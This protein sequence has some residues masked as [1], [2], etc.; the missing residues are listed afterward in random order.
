[1][2]LMLPWVITDILLTP[3]VQT[4]KEWIVVINIQRKGYGAKIYVRGTIL[5]CNFLEYPVLI[6]I[7]S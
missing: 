7:N 5:K 4:P 2:K 1:M 6:H 3:S